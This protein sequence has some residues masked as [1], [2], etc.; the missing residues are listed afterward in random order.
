MT[1]S[2]LLAAAAVLGLAACQPVPGGGYGGGGYYPDPGYS[3]GA[4]FRDARQECRREAGRAGVDVRRIL[5]ERGVR[6][7]SGR[8][9]RVEVEMRVARRGEARTVRC[10][11]GVQSGRAELRGL[12]GIGG[13]GYDR[14]D[15]RAARQSCRRAVE[16]EGFD[17]RRI[18]SER[19]VTGRGGRPERAELLL[20]AARR[21]DVREIRCDFDFDT[22]RTRL[23]GAGGGAGGGR[24]ALEDARRTCRRAVERQGFD[25]RRITSERVITGNRGRPVAAE[26]G[27]RAARRG[28]VR[29][30]LCTFDFDTGRTRLEGLGGRPGGGGPDRPGAQVSPFELQQAE[31]ACRRQ[32]GR[33]NLTFRRV[34]SSRGVVAGGPGRQVEVVLEV[35]RGGRT[36]PIRCLYDI[37][38]AEARLGG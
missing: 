31:R 4:V 29:D 8:L 26:I 28:D 11:Y 14:P 18:L 34:L 30:V 24:P 13:G 15:M 19:V 5:D 21:G 10:D 17:V 36:F 1:R 7:G 12:G 3:E 37:R 9:V 23:A 35:A 22:G 33:E 20:R 32:A 27:L 25:V 2:L 6:A 38:E 16:R